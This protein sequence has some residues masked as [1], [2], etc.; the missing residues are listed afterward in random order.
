V[1]SNPNLVFISVP[2]GV[3]WERILSIQVMEE[4]MEVFMY[5]IQWIIKCTPF[6]VISMIAKALGQ[7]SDVSCFIHVLNTSFAY[8]L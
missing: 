6:A 2:A 5:F 8:Q 3:D 1:Q 4:L 7:Q